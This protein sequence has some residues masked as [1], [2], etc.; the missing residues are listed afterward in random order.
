MLGHRL[1]LKMDGLPQKAQKTQKAQKHKSGRECGLFRTPSPDGS[2]L[3][4]CLLCVLCLLWL[5]LWLKMDDP[6]LERAGG[7]LGAVRHAQFSEDVVDVALH[8]RLAD[9]QRRSDLFVGLSLHD[10]LKHFQFA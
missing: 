3:L 9:V 5:L 6:A 4:L 1:Q 2:F 7:G 8:R 10:L